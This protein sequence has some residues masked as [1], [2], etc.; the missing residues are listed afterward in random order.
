M[1]HGRSRKQGADG[2]ETAEELRQEEGG[3]A[4]MEGLKGV[5]DS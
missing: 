5:K 1:Q 4:G 2:G 3:S